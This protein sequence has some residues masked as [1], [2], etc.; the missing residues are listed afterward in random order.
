TFIPRVSGSVVSSITPRPV[1]RSSSNTALRVV[2][3]SDRCYSPTR[4]EP[5]PGLWRGEHGQSS[6]A[7]SR[8]AAPAVDR[9]REL[10]DQPVGE[11]ARVQADDAYGQLTA[12][13]RD[14]RP[15]LYVE[16]P[17]AVAAQHRARRVR[18]DG[19][20]DGR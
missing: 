14:D 16:H 5:E 1:M 19:D 3:R 9:Q 13:Y 8:R 20:P 2:R 6:S 4:A 11:R 10:R 7:F 18:V 15:G 12:A 17:P